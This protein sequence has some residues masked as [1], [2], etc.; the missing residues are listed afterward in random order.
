MQEVENVEDE[1]T[2][3]EFDV[4]LKRLEIGNAALILNDTLNLS[5]ELQS[6]KYHP[7]SAA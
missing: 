6:Q 5:G 1:P 2:R 4:P 7:P 3:Q